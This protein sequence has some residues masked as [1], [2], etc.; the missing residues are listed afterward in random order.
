MDKYI[1]SFLGA[2][3]ITVSHLFGD[4]SG[5]Y[6]VGAISDSIRKSK[7]DGDRFDALF[8]AFYVPIAAVIISAIMFA[9]TIFTVQG[10]ID[11]CNAA[12]GKFFRFV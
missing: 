4:A 1:W 10:D 12:M 6:I 8:K 11:R 2:I 9:V 3:Q 5:P 7:Q